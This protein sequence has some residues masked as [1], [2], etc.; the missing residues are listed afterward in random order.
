[1]KRRRRRSTASIAV[2]LVSSVLCLGADRPLPASH[3]SE[4]PLFTFMQFS[5][6]H[7]GNPANRPVHRRLEA[8][9]K[10]ANSLAP[11]FVI[12]TGDMTTHPVYEASAANLAEYGEY[13]RY[14]KPLTMPRYN[15]PGNHDIGYFDPGGRTRRGGKPWGNYK[16]LVAAYRREL[17]P[18]DQS[19]CHLGFRFVLVNNNPPGSRKAGHLSAKQ[20]KWIE[21]ELRQGDTEFIFCHVQV[22]RDGTGPPWGESA[23]RLVA[24]CKKYGVAAVAYGHRHQRHVKTLDGTQYVMC[25]DLKMPGHQ[26]VYQYRVFPDRFELWLYD[27]FSQKGEQVSSHAYPR[28]AIPRR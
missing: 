28:A 25:P 19:F 1:M 24:M 9:V 12:D 17:G 13:K 7:V 10:L 16:A 27:V 11:A 8:A 2:L 20:L 22:L 6:V 5:D 26:A 14:V 15:V 21:G 18:I 23:E 4:P 3:R